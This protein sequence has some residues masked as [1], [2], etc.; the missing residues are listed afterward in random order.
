M[1]SEMP[2]IPQCFLSWTRGS[3]SAKRYGG[4]KPSRL[5]PAALVALNVVEDSG[6]RVGLD[7]EPSDACV[8]PPPPHLP[9]RIPTIRC[10]HHVGQILQRDLTAAVGQ[11]F[12]VT[13]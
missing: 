11:R 1:A 6:H 2:S 4:I 7:L 9:A 10:R 12:G 3:I 5:A 8:A 13:D